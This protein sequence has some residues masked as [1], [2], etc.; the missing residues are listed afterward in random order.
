MPTLTTN[1]KI[2][3]AFSI[4][5]AGILF[6]FLSKWRQEDSDDEV[7]I[8]DEF[9][10]SAEL[11]SEMQIPQCHVGAIIGNLLQITVKSGFRHFSIMHLQAAVVTYHIY[12]L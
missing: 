8:E 1:Q 7:G 5:I 3:L 2:A 4:P 6:Y 12:S 9:V 11:V 10:S